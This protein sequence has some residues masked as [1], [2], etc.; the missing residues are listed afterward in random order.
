MIKLLATAIRWWKRNDEVLGGVI[1]F[2]GLEGFRAV[3]F[4]CRK[5]R[6]SGYLFWKIDSGARSCSASHSFDSQLPTYVSSL[7]CHA[8]QQYTLNRFRYEL[9]NT[10]LSAQKMKQKDIQKLWYI[11]ISYNILNHTTNFDEQM[12]IGHTCVANDFKGRIFNEFL[13]LVGSETLAEYRDTMHRQQ[14]IIQ[15]TT[16][17]TQQE[18]Y[19]VL[20]HHRGKGNSLF[21]NCWVHTYHTSR[22][23]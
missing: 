1:D 11:N 8:N 3:T 19:L 13:F 10:H 7:V 18:R 14:E 9:P 5:T 23:N 12:K 22:E 4:R 15:P 21:M 6:V 20:Q 2:K 16:R 17:D